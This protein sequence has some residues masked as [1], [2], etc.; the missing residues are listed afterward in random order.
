MMPCY[1]EISVFFLRGIFIDLFLPNIFQ[2]P[3][4]IFVSRIP[5]WWRVP[6]KGTLLPL[7]VCLRGYTEHIKRNGCIKYLQIGLIEYRLISIVDIWHKT[8]KKRGPKVACIRHIR[9]YP[10][11]P[12]KEHI[13]IILHLIA[14]LCSF[15]VCY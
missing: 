11:L 1:Q 14:L 7:H 12:E 10:S 9:E 15:F 4:H 5:A 8:G 3:P 13:Q 2:P 6:Q